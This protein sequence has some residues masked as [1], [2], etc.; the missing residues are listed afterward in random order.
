M[1]FSTPTLRHTENLRLA[2][3]LGVV[4]LLIFFPVT[5][6]HVGW[7]LNTQSIFSFVWLILIILPGLYSARRRDQVVT[8]LL[9][10]ISFIL[11]LLGAWYWGVTTVD[12][13]ASVIPLLDSQSYLSDALSLVHGFQIS[14]F[15]ARRPFTSGFF[16]SLLAI[17]GDSPQM[18]ALI[19]TLLF[20]IT[21]YLYACIVT[22]F[23]K[24]VGAFLS[25]WLLYIFFQRFLGGFMT[26]PLGLMF[27][28]VGVCFLITGERE[29]RNKFLLIGLFFMSMAL[30]ARAGAFFF[31]LAMMIWMVTK[32]IQWKVIV[33]GMLSIAGGFICSFLLYFF[34]CAPGS[35]PLSN[36]VYVLYGMANRYAGWFYIRA[37]HPEIFS[38][39]EPDLSKKIL[40]LSLEKIRAD[41][42]DLIYSVFY[43]FFDFFHRCFGFIKLD[44][45]YDHTHH[46]LPNK[47]FIGGVLACALIGLASL[48]TQP[49][50]RAKFFLFGFLGIWLSSPFAPPI[51]SDGMRAYAA[52]FPFFV[53]LAGIGLNYSIDR[54]IFLQHSPTTR[55]VMGSLGSIGVLLTLLCVA[56]PLLIKFFPKPWIQSTQQTCSEGSSIHQILPMQDLVIELDTK[57]EKRSYPGRRLSAEEFRS[58]LENLELPYPDLVAALASVQD[59]QTIQGVF[60]LQSDSIILLRGDRSLVSHT[61]LNVCLRPTLKIALTAPSPMFEVTQVF[62]P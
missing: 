45:S 59:G 19:E 41:P 43:S 57:N 22:K 2:I 25:I 18:L 60:D 38:L 16:A 39:P 12:R 3:L 17:T 42:F 62:A 11:P 58:G 46:F 51:D 40:S 4:G 27:S 23:L 56:G 28:M 8:F 47:F 9:L 37:N 24:P 49:M 33:G 21:F 44:F 30:N 53:L 54:E 6:F 35:I 36:F 55:R 5:A 10:V 34:V 48:R 15:S 50:S 52:T 13:I 32:K 29:S 61:A 7:W 1:N 31:L 14:P 20:S 26:E